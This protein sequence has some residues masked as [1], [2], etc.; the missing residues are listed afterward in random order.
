M[1]HGGVVLAA[2]AASAECSLEVVCMFQ[3][4][5]H[6]GWGV[7]QRSLCSSDKVHRKGSCFS[8][9]LVSTPLIFFSP[10][11]FSVL[12]VFYDAFV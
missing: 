8:L 11:S 2:A 3:K 12:D 1:T 7:V 9:L 4:G 10:H 6:W 5:S